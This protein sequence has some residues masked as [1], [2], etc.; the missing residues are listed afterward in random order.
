MIVSV[1]ASGLASLEMDSSVYQP[2][3]HQQPPSLGTPLT[4]APRSIKVFGVLHLIF[5]SLGLVGAI[6]GFAFVIWMEPIISWFM[7]LMAGP[8]GSPEM[9]KVVE[10]VGKSYLAQRTYYLVS[11]I[12]SL[13]SVVLMLG[14]GFA[15]IKKKKKGPKASHLWSWFAIAIVLLNIPVTFMYALPMQAQMEKD[16]MEALGTPAATG[17]SGTAELIGQI[18]GMA[19]GIV[20]SLIYPIL[21]LV[22][23][24]KPE[25]TTLFGVPR[26]LKFKKSSKSC[27]FGLEKHG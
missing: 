24:R 21:A 13:V 14:A 9:A 16:M 3:Q 26:D 20:V 23:L 27:F 4:Q 17:T 1:V 19:F 2:P 15:L 11:T 25:V 12:F 8:D 10:I 6:F 7:G 5:G 18:V 22:F